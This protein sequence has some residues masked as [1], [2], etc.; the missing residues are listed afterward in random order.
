MNEALA[1]A[2]VPLVERPLRAAIELARALVQ[3][4]RIGEKHWKPN[5][6]S[7]D[8]V[9]EEWFRALYGEVDKWYRER[10]GAAMKRSS[11]STSKGFVVMWGTAFAKEVPTAVA[12][13]GEPGE[14]VWVS[15]PDSVLE[16][17][18]ASEWLVAPP[19]LAALSSLE[20]AEV[21]AEC[22][23][24]GSSLRSISVK[25]MGVPN[26]DDTAR[27]FLD[28]VEIHLEA[29]AAN[30]IRDQSEGATPR[31]YWE[32]Q[33]ACEC[34]YKAL[35]QAKIGK[36][37]E[38]HD[39]FTL[40][41]AAARAGLVANH[42]RDVLKR[43]PRWKKMIELRYGQHLDTDLTSFYDAYKIVLLLVGAVIAPLAEFV[44]GK[45]SIEIARPPW[46]PQKRDEDEDAVPDADKG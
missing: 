22:K 24:V 38:T 28:G 7:P 42:K 2:K 12:W 19:N 5:L 13:P 29:A 43:I 18:R 25:L 6:D 21:E 3:E 40:H 37:I 23:E 8:F 15:F 10:F 14:S 17:E 11:P 32:L 41:D 4:I 30:A 44:L 36:F 16:S 39:L 31:A 20:L 26:G 35:L 45:A 1:S 33:M 46:L 9:K 27:G 34:A